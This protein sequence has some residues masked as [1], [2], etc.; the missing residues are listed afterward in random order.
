[1]VDNLY[2]ISMYIYIYYLQL[3]NLQPDHPSA[4]GQPPDQYQ[5]RRL[6]PPF[7]CHLEELNP[8]KAGGKGM[9]KTRT[10]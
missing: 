4:K 9:K 10:V 3:T 1:M 5:C 7:L 2:I 6:A 8:R